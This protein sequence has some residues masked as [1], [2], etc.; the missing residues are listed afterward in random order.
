MQLLPTTIEGAYLVQTETLE[1]ERGFFLET[2]R[3]SAIEDGTGRR[4]RF[5]QGNHSRSARGTLRGFRTEP[6]DKLIYVAHGTAL[7]VVADTRP[8]SSGFLRHETFLIGD[9]PGRRLRVLV[10]RGLSNAF[11]CLTEV[12]YINDVSGEYQPQVRRGFRWDDPDIAV[13]W[14]D[15]APIL[16]AADRTLPSLRRMLA[17]TEAPP[18]A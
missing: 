7:I 4:Y 3:Q 10:T 15:P 13:D 14:P 8:D 9:P 6:W 16:S 17:E 1:D 12:D 11:Y 2:Y 18:T 5:A